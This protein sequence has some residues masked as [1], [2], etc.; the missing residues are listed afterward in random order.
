[1]QG[2]YLFP[3]I[4][5]FGLALAGAL[6]ARAG[7]APRGRDRRRRRRPARLPP[8]RPRPRRRAVLCV[9]PRPPSPSCSSSGLAGARRAWRFTRGSS[10]VYSPGASPQHA[11]DRAHARRPRL[12]GADA[13]PGRR[14]LRPRRAH[15]SVTVGRPARRYASRCSTSTAARVLGRRLAGRRLPGTATRARRAGR[16]GA[17]RR[18]RC[19]VCLTRAAGGRSPCSARPGPPRRTT[20]ATVDGSRPRTSTSRSALRAGGALAASRSAPEM[21]ER[22]CPV[23]GTAGS[24]PSVYLVLSAGRS[25]RWRRCCWREAS[26]GLRLRPRRFRR[27]AGRS[28]SRHD[29]SAS[30][31][32]TGKRDREHDPRLQ[33]RAPQRGD[34]LL[35]REARTRRSRRRRRR[36][37]SAGAAT[38]ACGTRTR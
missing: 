3:V 22:A 9:G 35:D 8:A 33:S 26:R 17:H 12:P 31:Y 30:A 13:Q 32:V 15:G 36:A 29:S 10:L 23:P 37:P 24:R 25:S 19:S 1:M 11:G 21:A 14:R 5:I 27:S 34:R 28:I 16:G 20:T 6:V 2:R 4:G 38:P 7:A 18:R